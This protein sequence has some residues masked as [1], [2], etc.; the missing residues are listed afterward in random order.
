MR[1]PTQAWWISRTINN[2]WFFSLTF[3]FSATIFLEHDHTHT[4][5]S[6]KNICLN[7]TDRPRRGHSRPYSLDIIL[8]AIYAIPLWYNSGPFLAALGQKAA[9]FYPRN[10]GPFGPTCDSTGSLWRGNACLAEVHEV[11]SAACSVCSSR[12]P[13]LKHGWGGGKSWTGSLFVLDTI[14][15]RVRANSEEKWPQFRTV[16]RPG[17][18]GVNNWWP[19]TRTKQERSGRGRNSAPSLTSWADNNHC[20]SLQCRDNICHFMCCFG[21]VRAP[22]VFERKIIAK[23]GNTQYWFVNALS[24]LFRYPN[25]IFKRSRAWWTLLMSL[26]R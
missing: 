2:I 10:F 7:V 11:P 12:P 9:I 14:V 26:F 5:L 20:S 25:V 21:E 3:L 19:R 13:Q 23:K 24:A 22:L 18:E 4:F 16:K 17:G 1:T 15:P 8:R 6:T